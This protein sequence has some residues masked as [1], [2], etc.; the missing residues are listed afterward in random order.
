MRWPWLPEIA[1]AVWAG[2]T[3][4]PALRHGRSSTTEHDRPRARRPPQN[5]GWWRKQRLQECAAVAG[6]CLGN[7]TGNSCE[8]WRRRFDCVRDGGRE[9]ALGVGKVPLVQGAPKSAWSKSTIGKY[10]SL[11]PRPAATAKWPGHKKAKLG[12]SP[13]R[14]VRPTAAP[15]RGKR[16]GA[17][18]PRRGAPR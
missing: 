7:P 1:T 4:S 16:Q 8:V 11:R 12:S 14:R 3:G 10:R 6:C 15:V 9:R 2:A 18:L 13:P 5:L 17:A